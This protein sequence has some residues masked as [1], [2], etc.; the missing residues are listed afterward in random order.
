VSG[1]RTPTPWLYVRSEP[2]LWTVGFYDPDG[3]W[4]SESDHDS[5]EAAAERVGYLSGSNSHDALIVE[6]NALLEGARLAHG[7]L[8]ALRPIELQHVGARDAVGAAYV[9]LGVALK[10]A[11]G[12]A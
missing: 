1:A 2:G 4:Q 9:H 8:G 7:L 10:A 5:P 12:E 6:R 3:K 11:K